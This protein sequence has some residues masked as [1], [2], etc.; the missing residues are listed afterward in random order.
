[1]DFVE[2]VQN[3]LLNIDESIHIPITRAEFT[4]L[5]SAFSFILPYLLGWH[6]FANSTKPDATSSVT[7]ANRIYG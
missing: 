6:A 4:V 1:M 2:G 5:K 3:E 7:N